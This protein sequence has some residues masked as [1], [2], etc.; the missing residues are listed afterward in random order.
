[1]RSGFLPRR[2][3][4]LRRFRYCVSSPSR[5]R[6]SVAAAPASSL[7]SNPK[8]RAPCS[9]P[10]SSGCAKRRRRSWPL[11]TRAASC[12]SAQV[13]QRPVSPRGCAIRSSCSTIRTAR[14]AW[15]GHSAG[16]AM[17]LCWLARVGAAAPLAAV[18]TLGTPGPR[19][20]G[21]VRRT[22]AA[23][24]IA[25]ARVLGRFP[26]RALRF[27]NED[28]AAEI[29]SEWMEWNVRGTWLGSDGFDYFAALA[30]ITTLYLGVAGAADRGFA[31]PPACRQ[32]GERV[33]GTPETL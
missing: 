21:P 6:R 7:S 12:K 18:V 17:G 10:S 28:E 22:L 20:L 27:G 32:G 2:S 1:M 15:I 14:P 31:P 16:G 25:L 13:S 8:C 33:G 23:G 4:S 29:I 26:A 11:A 3:R 30:S 24:T 19:R 9:R 5:E